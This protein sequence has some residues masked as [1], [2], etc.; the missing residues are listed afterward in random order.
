ML[1]TDLANYRTPIRLN[2]IQKFYTYILR[3]KACNT[4]L[5]NLTEIHFHTQTYTKN[6][7]KDRG[8]NDKW[9]CGYYQVIFGLST[10]SNFCTLN[11]YYVH[12]FF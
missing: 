1:Y 4:M 3:E 5:S 7:W 9:V 8:Q 10:F 12:S 2:A 6:V 11:M